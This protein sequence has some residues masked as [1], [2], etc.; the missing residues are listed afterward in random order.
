MFNVL[1]LKILIT[2]AMMAPFILLSLYQWTL[3]SGAEG[4]DRRVSLGLTEG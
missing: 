2:I 1:V 4:N 3:L